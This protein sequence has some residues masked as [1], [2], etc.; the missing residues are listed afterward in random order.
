M[1]VNKHCQVLTLHLVLGLHEFHKY[2]YSIYVL[3][4]VKN[5]INKPNM[6]INN[7]SK[8]DDLV[9]IDMIHIR[10]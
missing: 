8:A 4:D 1:F 9:I 3:G 6:L 2:D 7:F 5:I 10:F